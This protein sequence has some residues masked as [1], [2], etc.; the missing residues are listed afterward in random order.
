MC[1]NNLSLIFNGSLSAHDDCWHAR[2]LFLVYVKLVSLNKA[3]LA[4]IALKWFERQ[5][6]PYVRLHVAEN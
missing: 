2:V 1:L 3:F 4:D 5:V 6:K